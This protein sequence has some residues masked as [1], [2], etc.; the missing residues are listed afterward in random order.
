MISETIPPTALLYST[1]EKILWKVLWLDTFC[2]ITLKTNELSIPDIRARTRIIILFIINL[3]FYKRRDEKP[4][5]AVLA[6]VWRQVREKKTR[7]RCIAKVFSVLLFE[8]SGQGSGV[9]G[10]GIKRCLAR[11]SFSSARNQ[12]IRGRRWESLGTRP[13]HW[14]PAGPRPTRPRCTRQPTTPTTQ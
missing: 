1:L 13:R 5:R 6:S 11:R 7:N 9:D 2:K 8:K 14:L 3:I 4:H 10:L 12:S